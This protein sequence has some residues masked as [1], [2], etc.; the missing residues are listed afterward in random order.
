MKSSLFLFCSSSVSLL[1]I[2]C[3]FSVAPHL[4]LCS[5]FIPPPLLMRSSSIPFFL[6]FSCIFPPF[7]VCSSFAC[8]PFLLPSSSVPPQFIPYS[9]FIHPSFLLRSSSYVLPYLV[10][11]PLVSLTLLLMSSVTCIPDFFSTGARLSTESRS[12]VHQT[13]FICCWKYLNKLKLLEVLKGDDDG[14]PAGDRR[15]CIVPGCLGQADL[16]LQ[17]QLLLQQ[18]LGAVEGSGRR[19]RNRITCI[20][21]ASVSLVSWGSFGTP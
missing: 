21:M 2:N 5:S 20:R 9:S 14:P 16:P 8:P 19:R 12:L 13:F 18:A 1:F 3:Y 10:R 11:C 7:L 4:R 6:P 17:Q 15:S